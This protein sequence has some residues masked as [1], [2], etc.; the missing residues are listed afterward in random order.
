MLNEFF[1][2]KNISGY[3]AEAVCTDDA[4]AMLKYSGFEIGV[5]KK[6]GCDILSLHSS[7]TYFVTEGSFFT[8]A[9]HVGCCSPS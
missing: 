5:Q 1:I 6:C 2:S 4:L 3:L 8:F 7:S 9:R